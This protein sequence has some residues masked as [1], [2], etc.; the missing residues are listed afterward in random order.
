MTE[1]VV[2]FS[3][4]AMMLGRSGTTEPYS[5]LDFQETVAQLCAGCCNASHTPAVNLPNCPFVKLAVQDEVVQCVPMKQLASLERLE[6]GQWLP[7]SRLLLL[8]LVYMLLAGRPRRTDGCLSLSIS[9]SSLLC[10]RCHLLPTQL[11]ARVCGGDSA[12]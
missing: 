8:C 11:V 6:K 2:V 12:S 4:I 7:S 9:G 3:G 5:A 1:E 10:G